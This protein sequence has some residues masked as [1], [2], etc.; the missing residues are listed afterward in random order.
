MLLAD[1]SSHALERG[2]THMKRSLEKLVKRGALLPDEAAA[3][4]GRVN[5]SSGGGLEVGA[6]DGEG[7]GRMGWDGVSKVGFL[8]AEASV[9]VAGEV[10]VPT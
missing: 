4:L 5:A 1:S 3:A 10:E 8:G 7:E 9:V 2:L 6:G